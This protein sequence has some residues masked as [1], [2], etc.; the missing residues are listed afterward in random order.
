[1]LQRLGKVLY[2][3]A[4]VATGLTALVAVLLYTTEGYAKKDGVVL[5]IAFLVIAFVIW[6]AGLALRYVLS[7]PSDA[8][9]KSWV[10]PNATWVGT[11]ASPQPARNTAWEDTYAEHIYEG[12]VASDGLGDM[13][14]ERLRIPPAAMQHYFQKALFQREL[15]C[16]VA[17][18]SS[19]GPETNLCPVMVAYSKLL[20]QKLTARG[21]QFNIDQLADASVEDVGELFKNPFDWGQKWLAD[22]RNDPQDNCGVVMFADHCQRQFNAYKHAI[23]DTNRKTI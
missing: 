4:C 5:T 15:M 12:L 10:D 6:L 21:L 20:S 13:T 14:P 9:T 18:M 11:D 7:G 23:E 16:L 8:P 2:W 3:V 22:F 1:M 19:A 17:L